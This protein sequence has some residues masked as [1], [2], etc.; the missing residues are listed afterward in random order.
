MIEE[1]E[2]AFSDE[3]AEPKTDEE[4]DELLEPESRPSRLSEI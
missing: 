2:A 1:V 4:I 3:S